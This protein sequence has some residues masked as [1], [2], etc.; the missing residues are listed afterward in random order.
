[1]KKKVFCT[2]VLT[3]MLSV[4]AV[5]TSCGNKNT[6]ETEAQATEEQFEPDARF[7]SLDSVFIVMVDDLSDK[8]VDELVSH[9]EDKS[10]AVKSYWLLNHKG[11]DKSQMDKDV[12]GELKAMADSLSGGST[13]DM[14]T[15]GIISCAVAR[16]LT[17]KE[18]VNNYSKNS[19]Y[20]AEMNDW[21]VLEDE[22]KNFYCDL[23]EL[24]NWGGSITKVTSASAL[25]SL[26][27]ARQE[28]YSQLKKGGNFAGSEEMTISE[29]RTNMIQELEDAKSLEDDLVDDEDFRET[30]KN[31]RGHADKVVELLDKWLESRSK[32]CEAEGIPE[33][34]TAHLVAQLG[35]RIMEM[36]E[37]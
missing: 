17:T 25:A 14:M 19:L 36:I 2:F 10:L 20:Q 33:S 35:Q 15:S 16:Y 34:H 7:A 26:A 22:L 12:C 24:A 1:M 18:Y 5:F 11:G 3:A 27:E 29:A 13:A 30:L 32:L 6:A 21:L 23:A 8:T 9:F 37:G 31:M 4:L 28:D